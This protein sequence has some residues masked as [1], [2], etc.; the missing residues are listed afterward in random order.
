VNADIRVGVLA[1]GRGSNFAALA[2]AARAKTLGGRIV[3][4]VTDNPHAGAIEV[5]AEFHIPVTV[6]DAGTRRGRLPPAVEERIV[7][8]LRREGVQLVCLAGFMRIV[9]APLLQA[10]PAAILNVHPS[11][12]PSFPG[13]GAQ[14]QALRH[15]VR[16]AGCSVHFVD[17]GIDSGPIVLQAAVPVRDDDSETT[18]SARILAEEHRLFPEAVRLWAQGRLQLEGRRV[19]IHQASS[20][21]GGGAGGSA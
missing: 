7:S 21:A 11:L 12:L 18:L 6:V 8:V 17:A 3:A 15:G 2:A 16:V 5:A 20:V 1:S 10:Y 9:G 19:R 4:L 13:V 14:A